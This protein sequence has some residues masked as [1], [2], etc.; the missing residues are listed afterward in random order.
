MDSIF[1]TMF[2]ILMGENNRG[3][4]IGR[5]TVGDYTID[6]CYTIDQ[7]WE[8]GVWKGNHNTLIVGR[9]PSREAAEEGHKAWCEVCQLEPSQAWDVQMEEIISF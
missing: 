3:E 6:T 5:D 2:G 8:T 7:G 9:Y 4:V 1:S